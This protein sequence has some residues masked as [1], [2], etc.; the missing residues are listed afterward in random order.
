MRGQGEVGIRTQVESAGVKEELV[1]H[2]ASLVDAPVNVVVP[3]DRGR[4]LP[5]EGVV[6]GSAALQAN[7]VSAFLGAGGVHCIL[8]GA[9]GHGGVLGVEDISG[10]ADVALLGLPVEPGAVQGRQGPNVEAGLVA[11]RV[12][13]HPGARLATDALQVHGVDDHVAMG[14]QGVARN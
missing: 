2:R 6:V 1:V 9:A 10:V 3:V 8:N 14:Q 11:V 13:V 12:V 7:P 4:G 5:V